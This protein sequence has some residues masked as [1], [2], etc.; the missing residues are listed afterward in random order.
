MYEATYAFCLERIGE[1][2]KIPT[3]TGKKQSKKVV[4][5]VID[6]WNEKAK[7]NVYWNN[8]SVPS[9]LFDRMKQ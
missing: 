9:P 5:S 8:N 1:L 7:Q 3:I 2:I 4:L 6:Y